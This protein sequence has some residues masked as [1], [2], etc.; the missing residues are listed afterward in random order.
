MEL[1][2]RYSYRQVL[3]IKFC[4]RNFML[5]CLKALQRIVAKAILWVENNCKKDINAMDKASY[6][7]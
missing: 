5:P 2:S 6:Q 1:Q 4:A 3:A 7:C